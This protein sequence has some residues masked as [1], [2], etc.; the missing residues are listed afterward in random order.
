MPELPEV[1]TVRRGI[2]PL[3]G[4]PVARV[5]IARRDVVRDAAGRRRGRIDP[6]ALL[7]GSSL[8]STRRHGKQLALVGSSGACALVHRGLSVQLVVPGPGGRV[9]GGHA[10]IA[11]TME[12]GRRLVFRDPRRFG[13]V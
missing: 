7:Q 2:E 9:A 4:V 10:H 5:R 1:E 6:A 13:G 12:D 8:Q 3:I 11:W